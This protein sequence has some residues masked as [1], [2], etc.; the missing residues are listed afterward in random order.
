[1]ATLKNSVVRHYL[2]ER[3]DPLK[4]VQYFKENRLRWTLAD[5]REFENLVVDKESINYLVAQPA[6]KRIPVSWLMQI[7]NPDVLETALYK[8]K[9]KDDDDTNNLFKAFGSRKNSVKMAQ[10]FVSHPRVS[11]ELRR[12]FGIFA[13]RYPVP[14]AWFEAF[15]DAASD[16]T[17]AELHLLP[18]LI[19]KPKLVALLVRKK[20]YLLTSRD[21]QEATARISTSRGIHPYVLHTILIAPHI[22]K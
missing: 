5:V 13:S 6:V 22:K 16:T 8:V 7:D 19:R 12:R 14:P 18:G 4:L 2:S 11:E 1:M 10:T 21:F 9:I 3:R 17:I 20:G 15:L